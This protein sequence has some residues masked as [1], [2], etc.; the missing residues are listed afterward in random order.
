[1]EHSCSGGAKEESGCRKRIFT[2]CGP[3]DLFENLRY[4]PRENRRRGRPRG[5]RA[6]YPHGETLR[7]TGGQG[8]G[9]R[10]VLE[11]YCREEAD[12]GV[13]QE[14]FRNRSLERGELRSRA[15]KAIKTL[16]ARPGF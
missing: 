11:D 10:A 9:R 4:V 15:F 5:D 1:M 12:A 16:C 14:N 7:S 13:W 6:Q 3:E 2:R 8:I